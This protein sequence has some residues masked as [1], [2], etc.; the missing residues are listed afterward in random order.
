MWPVSLAQ[1]LPRPQ[2]IFP[3]KTWFFGNLFEFS[4]TEITSKSISPTFWIQILPYKFL[5]ML[6]IKIFLKTPKAHSNSSEIFSYDLIEFLVKK[7]FNIQELLGRK[8]K[9]HGTKLMHPSLFSCS[10]PRWEL[11][12]DTKNMIWSIL[13]GGSHNYKTKQSKL[14]SFILL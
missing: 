13:F 4:V 12:K 10:P 3:P 11:S 8:S 5:L 9:H 1:V 14:P 6:L 7:S 2:L